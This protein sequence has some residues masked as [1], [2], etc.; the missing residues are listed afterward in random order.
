MRVKKTQTQTEYRINLRSKIL[1]AAW[2]EFQANG[3]KSIRMDDI[4]RGLSI[5]KRTLYEICGNKEDLLLECIKE[6]NQNFIYHIESLKG[7]DVMEVLIEY[8]RYQLKEL[9]H[10]SPLFFEDLG[11][12]P[13]VIRSI[14]EFHLECRE[15]MMSFFER[16]IVDGYFRSDVNYD[17]VARVCNASLRHAM[18]SQMY[19]D[20]SM[21][22]IFRNIIFVSIRG[23]CT[24]KG[25]EAFDKHTSNL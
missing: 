18:N 23:F 4:A 24:E 9:H 14:D 7:L 1:K 21:Q 3:V 11:K 17:I 2:R 15:K 16:G 19:N 25:M 22:E 8:T 12:Y 6:H 10:T 13:N 20:Y 5:S